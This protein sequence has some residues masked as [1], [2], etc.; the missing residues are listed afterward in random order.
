MGYKIIGY[1][2]WHA[3]KWYV[4]RRAPNLER[5]LAVGAGTLLLVGGV[6]AA[7]ASRRGRS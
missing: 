4:H 3:G 6:G 5:N 1:I 2:V 7:V